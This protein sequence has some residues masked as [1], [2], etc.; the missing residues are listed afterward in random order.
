MKVRSGNYR[1]FYT[2]IFFFQAE[3][4]N[5][6]G[7]GDESLSWGWEVSK[8]TFKGVRK[9]PQTVLKNRLVE[10]K[11]P[12]DNSCQPLGLTCMSLCRDVLRV[13]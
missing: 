10:E 11:K 4:E 1:I 13:F 12:R 7:L 3:L 8:T 6:R 2:H 5:E 9:T